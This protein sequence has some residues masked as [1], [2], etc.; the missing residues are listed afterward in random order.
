MGSK[1]ISSLYIILGIILLL[2]LSLNVVKLRNQYEVAY[3]DG[4]F[5]KLQTAITIYSRAIEYIPS[6]LILLITLEMNGAETWIIHL[7]GLMLI[8]EHLLHFYYLNYVN[9]N[10]KS[11]IINT[12]YISLILIIIINIY[13]IPWSQFFNLY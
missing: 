4:G 5:S 9:N 3:G 6:T 7:C 1:M 2:K 10:Q 11:S 12:I 8:I 13:Y